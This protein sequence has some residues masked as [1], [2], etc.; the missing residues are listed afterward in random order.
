[1]C[2]KYLKWDVKKKLHRF[3]PEID[4]LHSSCLKE[5]LVLYQSVKL[6]EFAASLKL[7]EVNVSQG[8]RVMD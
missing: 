1:M 5:A 2:G 3:Q 4:Q 7:F 8:V 6:F